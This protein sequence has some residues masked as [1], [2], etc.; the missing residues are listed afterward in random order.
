MAVIGPQ[1]LFGLAK[2][3]RLVASDAHFSNRAVAI[4]MKGRRGAEHGLVKARD[5]SG[6]PW[7]DQ[8]LHPWGLLL[9]VQRY[10]IVDCP[11]NCISSGE[12]M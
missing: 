1:R 8:E 3:Q 9:T 5:A 10:D 4:R 6:F 7:T 11:I 2:D 12:N